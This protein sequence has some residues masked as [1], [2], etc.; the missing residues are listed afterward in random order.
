MM[1]CCMVIMHSLHDVHEMNMCRA[2]YVCL[3]V[4]M[5]QL[6]NRWTDLDEFDMNVTP[7]KATLTSYF[8]ISYN[9]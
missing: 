4:H 1:S 7:L 2:E 6:G 5:I 3:S 9:Q 8:L